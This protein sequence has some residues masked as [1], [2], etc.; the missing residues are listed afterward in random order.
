M[1]EGISDP[2]GVDPHLEAKLHI[3]AWKGLE[4]ADLMPLVRL[5]RSGFVLNE[6]LGLDIADAIEGK[7][8]DCRI[9]ARKPR[10]GRPAADVEATYLRN[11]KIAAFVAERSGRSASW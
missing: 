6:H 1:D 11:G 2:E 9:T 5:L 4:Q 7:S 10:A 3:D 8:A